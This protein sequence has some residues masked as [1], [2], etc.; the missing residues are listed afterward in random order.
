MS[1][2]NLGFE[3]PIGS[4]YATMIRRITKIKMISRK[5]NAEMTDPLWQRNFGI[6]TIMLKLY[7]QM[8]IITLKNTI[9][10]FM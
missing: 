3:L 9:T 2:E 1:S 5:L 10:L 8:D 4:E 7:S 6:N